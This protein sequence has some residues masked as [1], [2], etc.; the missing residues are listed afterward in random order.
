MANLGGYFNPTDEDRV[1][2]AC[3]L[4]HIKATAVDVS[5]LGSTLNFSRRIGQFQVHLEIEPIDI[6]AVLEEAHQ[7]L[8]EDPSDRVRPSIV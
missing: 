7:L 5:P 3:L 8:C 4:P 6:Q 2:I 1:A